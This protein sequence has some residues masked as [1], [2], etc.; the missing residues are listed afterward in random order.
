MD[1]IETNLYQFYRFIGTASQVDYSDCVYYEQ[2][3]G[4]HFFWPQLVFNLDTKQDPGFLLN[5]I[6]C[7]STK[8][9]FVL[10]PDYFLSRKDKA[11]LKENQLTPVK[12]MTGM[13]RDL[14]QGTTAML[15]S[16]FLVQQLASKE[17]LIAFEELVKKEFFSAEMPL[18]SG[19]FQELQF[20]GEARVFG[21]FQNQEL[22]SAAM[23]V[24]QDSGAG[25]YFIVTKREFQG[26]GYASTLIQIILNKLSEEGIEEVVL[27]ANNLAVGLYE[28]LGF[29]AQYHFFVYKKQ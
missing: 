3:A 28:K 22:I 5:Q 11:L 6:A 8:V 24:Q 14:K 12:M 4:E 16:G 25:L 20:G 19:L 2:I 18:S 27:H 17:H 21:L 7:S 9:S 13:N 10:A 29:K 23:I 1:T 15:N 26:R